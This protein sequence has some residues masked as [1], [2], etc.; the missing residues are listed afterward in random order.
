MVAYSCDTEPSQAVRR[1]AD[2]ADMLIH[3]STGASVGHTSPA[4]AG[5]IAT[6]A[7]ARSLLLIHYPPQLTDPESL[8]AQARQ[9]FR[10]PIFVAHDLMSIDIPVREI[11]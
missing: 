10:G 5:E 3:E 9:T 7:G 8:L 1:L 4:K 6:Q 2:G 11:D